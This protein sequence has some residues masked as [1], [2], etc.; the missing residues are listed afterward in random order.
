M[1]PG[2]LLGRAAFL[3]NVQE[4]QE[5]LGQRLPPLPPP[6][7]I[8]LPF[9]RLLLFLLCLLLLLVHFQGVLHEEGESGRV[10]GLVWRSCQDQL[11]RLAPS[12]EASSTSSLMAVAFFCLRGAE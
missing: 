9:P 4:R 3:G 2:L 11:P 1:D 10:D 12:E 5:L 6:P 8:Q 7:L